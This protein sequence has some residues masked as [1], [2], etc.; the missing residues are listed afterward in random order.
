MSISNYNE[1]F[2]CLPDNKQLF[3]RIIDGSENQR[4]QNIAPQVIIRDRL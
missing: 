3:F 1:Q 4:C 2:F